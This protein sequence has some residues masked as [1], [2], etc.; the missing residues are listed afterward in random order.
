MA[1][2]IAVTR[3]SVHP[4]SGLWQQS[5]DQSDHWLLLGL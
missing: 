4:A 3:R 5:L 2:P 1:L